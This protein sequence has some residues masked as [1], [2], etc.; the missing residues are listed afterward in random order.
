[1]K[2]IKIYDQKS[3][4]V[5]CPSLNVRQLLNPIFF[6]GAWPPSSKKHPDSTRQ[7]RAIQRA[8]GL[9]TARWLKA[10]I[11]P[12][13]RVAPVNPPDNLDGR[14]CVELFSQGVQGVH[15]GGFL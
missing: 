4:L 10:Q 6:A 13:C 9:A 3:Y 11:I 14:E 15:G 5:P 2:V 8:R 7:R 12:L 1:M